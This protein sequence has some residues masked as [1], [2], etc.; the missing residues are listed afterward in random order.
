MSGT[1]D[2][3]RCGVGTLLEN[4]RKKAQ[5]IEGTERLGAKRGRAKKRLQRAVPWCKD[6]Q[7]NQAL[8][9]CQLINESGLR[10]GL[11]TDRAEAKATNQIRQFPDS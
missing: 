11:T 3:Y 1:M 5:S 9:T 8:S 6:L 4:R 2:N 7:C 10:A